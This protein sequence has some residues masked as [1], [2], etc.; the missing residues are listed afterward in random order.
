MIIGID[1]SP[2]TENP[3]GIQM[4]MTNVFAELSR[5]AP[6]NRYVVYGV[7]APDAFPP[8][9]GNFILK[10]SMMYKYWK[11]WRL[12]FYSGFPLQMAADKLNVFLSMYQMIP[13]YGRCPR[14]AVIYDITPVLVDNATSKYHTS[15]FKWQV[16]YTVNNANRII[17]ISEASKRDL[18][19]HFGA[20]PGKISVAYPGYSGKVFHPSDDLLD[21]ARVK[22]KFGIEGEYILYTGTLQTNK[23]IPRL[24][25]AFARLKKAGKIPHK[26]VLCGKEEWGAGD[27]RRAVAQSG[28]ANDVVT[29]GYVPS[30]DLPSLMRGATAFVFPSMYEG[31]G[32]PVLEAMACGVPVVVSNTS[33]LPEV[34]GDAGAVF[35]P[36][37]VD[38]MASAIYGVISDSN[39]RRIMVDKGLSRSADFSWERTARSILQVIESAC[40]SMSI[41]SQ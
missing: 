5:L 10:R 2:F 27:I 30:G 9:Y 28:F 12:W 8:E 35:D 36:F 17:T 26:L 6:G 25:E 37:D 13:L 20:S 32:M 21:T 40:A 29:T 22:A 33:S 23:N 19:T 39:L 31:F 41:S 3:T 11:L 1:G 15:I 18:V 38:G 16:R 14:I 7:H 4:F 34:V 24:V